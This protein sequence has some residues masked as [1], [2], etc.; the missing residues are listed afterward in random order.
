MVRTTCNEA[1]EASMGAEARIIAGVTAGY[2]LG[3]GKKMRLALSLA[4]MLAGKQISTDPKVLAKQLAEMVESNPRL[5][6][7]KGEVTGELMQAAQAAATAILTNRMNTLSDSLKDRSDSLRGL[8]SQ[9]E[10]VEGELVE[11]DEDDGGEPEAG[12]QSEEAPAEE[13]SDAEPS[14]AEQEAPPEE[15]PEE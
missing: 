12:D 13:P 1:Q 15:E 9:I 5:A 4:G 2:L 8:A 6:E 10:E 7:L 14:D 3:R 11:D